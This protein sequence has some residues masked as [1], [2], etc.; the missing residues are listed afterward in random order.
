MKVRSVLILLFGLWLIV[1][2]W[3]FGYT[4]SGAAFWFSMGV[5]LIQ[6][7]ASLWSISQATGDSLP[8]LITA[9]T[10]FFMAI[11]PFLQRINDHKQLW[12]GAALG[13]F[14]IL[15][16]FVNLGTRGRE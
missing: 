14:T 7:A 16:S 8:N 2:P 5:G 10:G 6:I 3:V 11:A 12:L 13:V 9:V 4:E 15:C 1:S